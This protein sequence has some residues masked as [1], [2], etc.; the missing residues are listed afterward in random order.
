MSLFLNLLQK[1]FGLKLT[2]SQGKTPRHSKQ[3][4]N[5]RPESARVYQLVFEQAV[6]QAGG[7]VL[8]DPVARERLVACANPKTVYEKQLPYL[9]KTSTGPCHVT[10]RMTRGELQRAGIDF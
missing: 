2:S 1:I 10:I 5:Q 4:S 8:K 3:D 6:Q 7:K 9:T